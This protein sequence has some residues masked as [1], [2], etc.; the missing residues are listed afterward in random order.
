MIAYQDGHMT[1]KME[2]RPM[3]M[4]IH[5]Y[6]MISIIVVLFDPLNIYGFYII[7]M[8]NGRE[9][10]TSQY[11]EE[12]NRIMFYIN[13]GVMGL[14]KQDVKKI[15]KRD[16]VKNDEYIEV[17]YK[18]DNEENDKKIINNVKSDTVNKEPQNNNKFN[19]EYIR[20]F[21]I[22]KEDFKNIHLMTT[23][24]IY[25]FSARLTAFKK[26][27]INNGLTHIYSDQFIEA[28]SIGDEMEKILNT[29]VQ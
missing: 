28:Y 27:I 5:H 22:I 12:D 16:F 8:K 24:E 4:R 20:E 2:V 15:T 23:E 13:N 1:C 7:Q 19:D 11:W 3:T 14:K 6:V 25:E 10:S 18:Y 17:I 9:L 21:E 26:K 29:R